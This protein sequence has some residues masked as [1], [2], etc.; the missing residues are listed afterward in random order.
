MKLNIKMAVWHSDALAMISEAAVFPGLQ[1][2]QVTAA[3]LVA[4]HQ[5]KCPSSSLLFNLHWLPM[6]YRINFK[7]ATLTYKILVSGRPGYL[8]KCLS[9]YPFTG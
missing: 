8:I 4:Y 7:I 1:R 2:I 9:T 3:H 5:P 6:K